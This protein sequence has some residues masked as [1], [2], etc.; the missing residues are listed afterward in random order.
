MYTLAGHYCVQEGHVD[1]ADG[2]LKRVTGYHCL[3][4]QSSII[5]ERVPPSFILKMLLVSINLYHLK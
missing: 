5:A 4:F 2:V 3:T 1:K